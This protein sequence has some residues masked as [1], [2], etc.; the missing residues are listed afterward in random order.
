MGPKNVKFPQNQ[1]AI[2][3][4]RYASRAR[5]ED[6]VNLVR[7]RSVEHEMKDTVKYGPVSAPRS[8]QV[9][10]IILNILTR[11]TAICLVTLGTP[12]GIKAQ[13]ILNPLVPV[14]RFRLGIH[15]L[16]Q[17]ADSRFGERLEGGVLIR[18]EEPL[19]LDFSDDAIG[20]RIFPTLEA[21]EENLKTATAGSVDPVVLGMGQMV[22]SQNTLWM[23]IRADVGILDWLTIGAMVPLSRRSTELAMSY[24]E[25]GATVGLTPT[26]QAG[27]FLSD[28]LTAESDLTARVQS[29]CSAG[30]SSTE[31]T[32]T[33]NLL[34]ESREFHQAIRE[35]YSSHGVFPLDGSV[36]GG[37]LQSRLLMLLA[38]YQSAGVASFPKDIPL[39]TTALS[40]N[41]YKSL[42]TTPSYGIGGFPIESWW[43]P[44]SLGDVELY[45]NARLLGSGL[46]R[47]GAETAQ[48]ISY[49][50]G[51]G[52]LVRLGTGETDHPDNFFDTGSGDGQ[53][54]VEANIFGNVAA[55][56]WSIH[57][58]ARYGIQSSTLVVRRVAG[59]DRAFPGESN[60]QTVS[61]TPGKYWQIRAVPLLHISNELA[62]AFDI[63]RYSKASDV[64]EPG[65]ASNS[66]NVDPDILELE[67]KQATLETG[68]GIVFSTLRAGHGHL[69]EARITYRHT[70]SG[71]GGRTPKM[72]HFEF[73]LRLFGRLWN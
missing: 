36:T 21:L 7:Q 26:G 33:S 69:L 45:A 18:E 27:N 67:T 16:L 60:R 48:K 40:Q 2:I 46:N 19:G 11:K 38:A 13:G 17:V 1:V 62:V 51:A 44:W 50:L 15:T 57:G 41:D 4:P 30:P 66:T 72:S 61:W 6:S 73:G 3:F 9:L 35:A 43:S 20:S 34:A 23:P 68:G 12:S 31:C 37:A 47:H 22:I 42:V 5:T 70:V 54:D 59:P 32:T 53:T 56:R 52:A 14:G 65:P 8:R 24:R 10:R 28:L 29:W 63:R 49:L 58:D 71:N 55:S 64:Y 39:A 25:D